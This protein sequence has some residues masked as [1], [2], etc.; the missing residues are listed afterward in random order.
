M[1][2]LPCTSGVSFS[3]ETLSTIRFSTYKGYTFDPVEVSKTLGTHM[4]GILQPE[5]RV[6]LAAAIASRMESYPFLRW[7]VRTSHMPWE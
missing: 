2:S 7:G 3:A 1:S 4:E 6:L 5:G